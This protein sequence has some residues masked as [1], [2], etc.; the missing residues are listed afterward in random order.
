M[1]QGDEALLRELHAGLAVT[2]SQQ[3]EINRRLGNIERKLENDLVDPD[4][5][6]SIE[7]DLADRKS[8]WT[9][10]IQTVGSVV[11][12]TLL[13]LLGKAIGVDVAN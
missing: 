10:I 5:V 7:S 1:A 4:R 12:I 11:A 13:T 9:W 6:A 3:T 2:Q 8:W